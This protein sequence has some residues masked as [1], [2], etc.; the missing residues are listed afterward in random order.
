MMQQSLFSELD[1]TSRD[2]ET[3]IISQIIPKHFYLFIFFA[4]G[5][6]AAW[7]RL[8]TQINAAK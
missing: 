7:A 1:K 6:G 5:Y 2:A 8:L 3:V 4:K